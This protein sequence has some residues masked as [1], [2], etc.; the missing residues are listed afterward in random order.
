V[1]DEI[2]EL[3]A[4]LY[5]LVTDYTAEL[6]RL[7]IGPERAIVLVTDLVSDSI[8]QLPVEAQ[9][10]LRGDVEWWTIESYLAA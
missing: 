4:R 6:S 3:R 2:A 9:D 1:V 10:E 8:R 5:E 7:A